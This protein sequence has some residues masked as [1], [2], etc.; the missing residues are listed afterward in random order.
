MTDARVTGAIR[1]SQ[2]IWAEGMLHARFVRSPVAHAR[3]VSIDASAVPEAVVV[4]RPEDVADLARYGPQIKDQE[5]LPQD[6]VRYAGDVVCAVAAE[7][8][9]QAEEAVN[10]IG[11]EYE[12]LPA[13]FDELEGRVPCP[14]PQPRRSQDG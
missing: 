12:E 2:D 4:L 3:I 6:R 1:Y 7:T 14:W 8:P 9:E 5:A 10:L 11:V 13:V